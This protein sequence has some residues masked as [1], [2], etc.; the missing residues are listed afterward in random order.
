MEPNYG[1]R[2]TRG[3]IVF[4]VIIFCGWIVVAHGAEVSNTGNLV[5]NNWSNGYQVPELT[6]WG[7]E[8]GTT[9]CSPGGRPY[10]RPDGQINF[11]YTFTELY[12]AR[13]IADVLPNSG[14]GLM[15]TGF[16]F[17]WRSKNG[18]GW[19][20]GRLDQLSAYVQV[21]NKGG[22]W[23][24]AQTYN[25]NFIHNWTDF[26]WSGN[27]TKERRGSDLGTILYGFSGKDN[28][29]WVG[30]YGP[31]ITN[32]SFSLRY[33]S[34]PCVVNPLHSTECPGFLAA[35]N[36]PIP[37]VAEST[38]S[39][40]LTTTQSSSTTSSASMNTAM[41]VIKLNAQRDLAVAETAVEQATSTTTTEN[42]LLSAGNSGTQLTGQA[43]QRTT[44]SSLDTGQS[45]NE[46]DS[47]SMSNNTT[48]TIALTS[49]APGSS[50]ATRTTVRSQDIQT[51]GQEQEQA[52]TSPTTAAV[53]V[54]VPIQLPQGSR[55]VQRA[56][57]QARSDT[58]VEG[59]SMDQMLAPPQINQQL[60]T[61][62]ISSLPSTPNR[63]NTTSQTQD[64]D[65]STRVEIAIVR[66]P[67]PIQVQEGQS[68]ST[69]PER[70]PQENSTIVM[71]TIIQPIVP[72]PVMPESPQIELVRPP[73]METIAVDTP[74]NSIGN[75]LIDRTNPLNNMLSGQQ[76]IAQSGPVFAGPA[77]KSN[78]AD[79]D[80]ASGVS[81]S[82]IARVPA[83]FDVYT[84]LAIR[85]IAF[86]QPRE[87][88][89]GQ[90]TIDNV[91]ALRS[92]G[93]DAK[94]QEMVDQQYRR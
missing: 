19:D 61:T 92:L 7:N 4:L 48:Q 33:Q 70:A 69:L 2:H 57:S 31:E 3:F 73:Q 6:C 44:S 37:G 81:I 67:E 85:E 17:N 15:A 41:S 83:G 77:V 10:V 42:R 63:T 26:S 43:R 80:L 20:D 8:Q 24:E 55:S 90:R 38:A 39:Y 50:A 12:Q 54:S 51:S 40:S 68:Q 14:T 29:Y 79:N 46:Q 82:Q 35:I 36:K 18:N 28:N 23:I 78:T 27:F 59:L 87:I 13:A 62:T 71:P 56:D 76:Q 58:V 11:S 9:N 66:M 52:F 94:H 1:Y 91:R 72:A 86:Y 84:N 22:Q 47:G 16:Q 30:P 25:L 75:A 60:A 93:Q 88:Y 32:V 65:I 53:A 34:D 74:S 21:Y 5:N 45:V 89:R 49:T 64:I